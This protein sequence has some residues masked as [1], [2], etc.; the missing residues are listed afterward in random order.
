[1]SDLS[2]QEE[3]QLK[4]LLAGE[5]TLGQGLELYNTL[6]K[7]N[8][9]FPMEWELKLLELSHAADPDRKDILYR[10]RHV[11]LALGYQ[12]PQDVELR[13]KELAKKR[14]TLRIIKLRQLLITP[15]RGLMTPKS[16]FATLLNVCSHTL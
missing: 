11:L 14:S 9:P 10:Y 8:I 6:T 3:H 5:A 7:K 15:C 1:M 2:K 4:M 12:V 13:A 16:R